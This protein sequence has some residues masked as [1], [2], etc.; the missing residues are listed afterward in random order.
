ML[1][2]L[3]QTGSILAWLGTLSG[4]S[5]LAMMGGIAMLVATFRLAR[6][7]L[8]TGSKRQLYGT[9]TDDQSCSGN[10]NLW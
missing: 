7:L 4:A 2:I 6:S 8:K 1:A 3:V 9:C 5:A 10:G